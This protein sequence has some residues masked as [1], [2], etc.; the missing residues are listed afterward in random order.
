MPDWDKPAWELR[1]P[2]AEPQNLTVIMAAVRADRKRARELCEEA[3]T[4]WERFEEPDFAMLAEEAAGPQR[5]RGR[6]I[7]FPRGE[8][9]GF[10]GPTAWIDGEPFVPEP[11]KVAIDTRQGIEWGKREIEFTNA[12]FAPD[13]IGAWMLDRKPGRRMRFTRDG[14]GGPK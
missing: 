12:E 8:H 11:L 6:R 1:N 2:F 7:V 14:K 3:G 5:L 9:Q 4:D 10:D 13:F